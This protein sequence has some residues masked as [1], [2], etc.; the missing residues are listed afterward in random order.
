MA[1]LR[2]EFLSGSQV[3]PGTLEALDPAGVQLRQPEGAI[4]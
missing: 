2:A 3:A 4:L 1:S